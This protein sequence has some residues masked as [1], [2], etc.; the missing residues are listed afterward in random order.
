MQ[1]QPARKIVLCERWRGSAPVR[2][3]TERNSVETR[4]RLAFSGN[5]A[6]DIPT[7]QHVPRMALIVDADLQRHGQLLEQRFRAPVKPRCEGIR[8]DGNRD[9]R[10]FVPRRAQLQADVHVVLKQAQGFHVPQHDFASSGW[11]WRS[12]AHQQHGGKRFLQRLDTLRY[13]ASGNVERIG[14]LL[15][16]PVFRYSRKS[17][18][19]KPIKHDAPLVNIFSITLI[20][21]VALYFNQTQHCRP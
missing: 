5:A 12:L 14:R 11:R 18:Q 10:T 15:E 16:T 13:S 1:G 21:Y 20:F 2:H 17:F 8:I 3:R 9:G 7:R 4:R 19:L 6:R